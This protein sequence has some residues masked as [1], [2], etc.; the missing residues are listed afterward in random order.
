[1]ASRE[2]SARVL[3]VRSSSCA[4]VVNICGG[5]CG[6]GGGMDALPKPMGMGIGGIP[7]PPGCCCWC[8]GASDMLRFSML[9]TS[10]PGFRYKKRKT[11][12]KK[13]TVCRCYDF[14]TV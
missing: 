8:G 7:P 4:A 5:S 1:M 11:E 2:K 14:F 10:G 13:P 6:V 12:K 9:M 3:S